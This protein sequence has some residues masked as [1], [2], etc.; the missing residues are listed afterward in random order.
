MTYT[1]DCPDRWPLPVIITTAG[2]S[3]VFPWIIGF[4]SFSGPLADH[5]ITISIVLGAVSVLVS[6]VTKR[7]RWIPLG[8]LG[9]LSPF[10]TVLLVTVFYGFTR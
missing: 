7:Y 4:T 6:T 3:I 9:V 2:L 5:S 8:V 10:L 1:A